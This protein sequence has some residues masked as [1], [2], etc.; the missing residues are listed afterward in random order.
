MDTK[1]SRRGLLKGV[2]SAA[3]VAGLAGALPRLAEGQP[4]RRRALRVAHLTD[5][6]VFADRP[7]SDQGIEFTVDHLL[8]L[9]DGPGLVLTGGDNLTGTMSQ[10]LEAAVSMRD[11][12]KKAFLNR[13]KLPML[14]CTGNH[15]V[16]GWNKQRSG[17]TGEEPLWGKAWARDQFELD[18]L[19][20]AHEQAGWKFIVL[21]SVQPAGDRYEGGIDPE[22]FEWL[23]GELKATP[24]STPVLVL[25]HI[26]VTGI[27][28][29][30]VDASP[31]ENGHL[32]PYGSIL[33]N[34]Y[35]VVRLFAD[36][37]QVKL[38]LAGHIHFREEV[39]VAGC[40]YLNGGAVSGAWWRDPVADNRSRAERQPD[41]PPRLERARPGYTLI[42][43]MTDGTFTL[44]TVD[45]GFKASP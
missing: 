36:H 14:H 17:S 5:M 20:Y 2:G 9:S 39:K 4:A 3:A 32:V 29:L 15:D 28:P 12:W 38:V 33:R 8:S 41:S 44:E 16:W 35:E 19:S 7:E 6:H 21:D 1:I 45:T 43:L 23:Q 31:A 30:I 11:R 27:S 18:R 40:T 22:Q 37:P 13:V 10:P 24:A 26:P 34:Q 42:D 25:S